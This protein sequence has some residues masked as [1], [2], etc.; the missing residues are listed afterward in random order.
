MTAAQ[1]PL[2]ASASGA[3][4]SA[5]ISGLTCDTTYHFRVVAVNSAG[6][7]NGPDTTFTTATCSSAREWVQ[8]AYVAYYGRPADPGGLAYWADRMEKEGGS[9]TSIIVAFGNS[10]EFNRRYGGLT[11]TELVTKIYLQTLNRDPDPDGL[12]YYVD[13]LLA[14]RRTLQSITLD[15]LNGATTEPDSAVVARK[16]DV[17]S[18]FTAK[19]SG[20]CDYGG[21]ETGFSTLAGVKN[22]ESVTAAKDALDRRCTLSCAGFSNT[23][24]LNRWLRPGSD[25]TQRAYTTDVGGFGGGDALVVRLDIPED[26]AASTGPSSRVVIAE[27]VDLPVV[28]QAYLSTLPCDFT[29]T[30]LGA[31]SSAQGAGVAFSIDIGTE[32]RTDDVPAVPPGATLYVNVRNANP[33]SCTGSCNMFVGIQR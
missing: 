24:V 29:T 15:V 32:R 26:A 22:I 5:A 33:D 13:E 18:Y 23:R 19:V 12:K 11:H 8:K 2:A 21:E 30:T 25:S 9:L 17:A 3:V 28:R 1:S 6:T 16:L 27:W 31:G 4:V 7:T 14:G 20:G 10:E